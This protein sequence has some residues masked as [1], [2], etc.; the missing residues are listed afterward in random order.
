MDE[1][2]VGRLEAEIRALKESNASLRSSLEVEKA[3]VQKLCG[4]I[5]CRDEEIARLKLRL[6]EKEAEVIA[7]KLERDAAIAAERTYKKEYEIANRERKELEERCKK[8]EKAE[9]HLVQD[10]AKM[11][12]AYDKRVSEVVNIISKPLLNK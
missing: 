10:L 7:V 2:K 3:E 5:V 12:E 11:Q 4:D 6:A 1:N 8:L 9:K